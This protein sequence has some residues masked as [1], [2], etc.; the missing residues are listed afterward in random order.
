MKKDNETVTRRPYM[1]SIYKRA[2]KVWGLIVVVWFFLSL[3][4]LFME[5]VNAGRKFIEALTGCGIV[6]GAGVV[7]GGM[8]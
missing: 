7:I 1:S 5:V 2:L 3:F 6:F 8:G 4:G